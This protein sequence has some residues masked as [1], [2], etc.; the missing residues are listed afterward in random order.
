MLYLLAMLVFLGLMVVQSMTI[1][2]AHSFLTGLY[3]GLFKEELSHKTYKKFESDVQF[4]L[5]SGYLWLGVLVLG[6]LGMGFSMGQYAMM[7]T[8]PIMSLI[9]GLVVLAATVLPIVSC[10]LLLN[11]LNKKYKVKNVD[12]SFFRSILIANIALHG[13]WLLLTSFYAYNGYRGS[14]MG[15]RYTKKSMKIMMDE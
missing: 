13:T 3:K 12:L 10:A 11:G 5:W 8:G 6:V 9:V 7:Y 15:V 14:G 4:V 2:N 1:A